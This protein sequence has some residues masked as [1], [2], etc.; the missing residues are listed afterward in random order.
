[1]DLVQLR[2]L[3]QPLVI[4]LKDVGTHN[5]LP[6]ICENLGLPPPG[7]EGSK[8]DR[9]TASFEAL[10]ATDL[11]D[12]AKRFLQFRPPLAVKR[13]EIQDALWADAAV[14]IPKKFRRDLARALASEELYI[15]AQQFDNLLDS[16]WI[17]DDDLL[18]VFLGSPNRS[19]RG[20][21]LQHVHKNPD[22]WSVEEL[23]DR[24]GAFDASNRRFALFIEGLASANVR[25]DES[26]QRRFVQVVNDSLK[27]CAVELRESGIEGGYPVFTI[28][29]TREGALGR[30]KNLIFASP[31]KPDLRFRDAVNND[32]EIVTNADKVLVYDRPIG[33]EGLLWRDLQLWWSETRAIPNDDEAK[34]TLYKRLRESLPEDSPPQENLFDA[35]YRGFGSAVPDLPALLPEVWLHWDPKTVRERGPDALKRFRMDFLLLLPSG[36]RVVI[37]V[38]GKQH[39][40]TEDG[41]ADSKRYAAMVAADRD[42][43]L[44][45]YQVFRFGSAELTKETARGIVKTFFEELFKRFGVS[46]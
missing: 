1:M 40:A 38:D 27:K 13:N 2:N 24:L 18:G 29:S 6:N 36:V 43:K 10:S 41:R 16:L 21:I 17:L 25:P 20:A 39:Y 22:D 34:K 44:A 37:E 46:L 9:I 5:E 42:L 8:R 31:I 11:P 19:L 15:D 30:P 23:F 14:D 3:L 4:N 32:I 28:V 33:V 26:A 45:G 7:L 12:V 35:F